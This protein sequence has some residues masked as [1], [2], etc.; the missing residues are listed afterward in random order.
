MK[1]ALFFVT[2]IFDARV[3]KRL[4]KI[5]SDTENFCDVYITTNKP[6]NIPAPYKDRVRTWSLEEMKKRNSLL[7]SNGY[8]WNCH[9][10][11]LILREKVPFYD[12]FWF[13]EYDVVYT[14]NWGD[15][16]SQCMSDDADLIATHL[17][18]YTENDQKKWSW[19][20]IFTTWD[21]ILSDTQKIS[22]FF[23]VYRISN[24]WIDAIQE[25][26]H[27]GWKGHF[28]SLIPTAIEFQKGTLH[29]L[30]W[31]APLTPQER[32]WYYYT[33]YA[34]KYRTLSEFRYA[35]DHVV[36]LRKK[37]LYHPVKTWIFTSLLGEFWGAQQLQDGRRMPKIQYTYYVVVCVLKIPFRCIKN[38]YIRTI[39]CLFE[40]K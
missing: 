20:K 15:I 8:L 29:E 37:T 35:P 33:T 1:Q 6:E 17:K 40:N 7:I 22:G 24:Q 18:R 25:S 38:M 9:M 31:S 5:I 23:P 16:I 19:W 32:K 28:E 10:T 21:D 27:R 4:K 39:Y 12:F 13:I 30:G 14:G 26:I 11:P 36:L 34:S 2:H 3:E